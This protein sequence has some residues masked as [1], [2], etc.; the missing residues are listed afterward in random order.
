MNIYAVVTLLALAATG[1][2][3]V[4]AQNYP[5]R[6]IKLVVPSSPGGGTDIIGRI[7]AQKLS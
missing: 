2:Q 6:A 7:V 5:N 3:P 1:A 4:L